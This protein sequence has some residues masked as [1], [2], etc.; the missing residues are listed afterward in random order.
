MKT[1]YKIDA[2]NNI[3]L[4]DPHE[5]K[6]DGEIFS[7]ESELL[8]LTE[9][10]PD[11]RLLKVR[12]SM[13]GVEPAAKINSSKKVVAMIWRTIHQLMKPA[14]ADTEPKPKATPKVG[15]KRVPAAKTGRAAKSTAPEGNPGKSRR[16]TSKKA[17]VL[18]MIR[19]KGGATLDEIVD[20][21]G[22]QKHTVRGFI[23]TVPAKVGLKVTSEKVDNHRT[24]S[25]T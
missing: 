4:L 7:S 15:K 24:Y 10:W 14:E 1:T 22:W 23:A 9:K 20:K 6:M 18:A 11:G 21:T 8:T 3:A 12:N 16:R 2:N 17:M 25:A 19:R 13:P 5:T